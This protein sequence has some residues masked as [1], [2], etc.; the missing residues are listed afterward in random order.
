MMNRILFLAGGCFWGM[1][2]Y[3]SLIP[4]VAETEVGYANG[5][6]QNPTYEQVC[7]HHTGHAETVKV[8]YD[9]DK[10]S[11]KQLLIRFVKAIDPTSVNRQGNDTGMQYRTGIYFTQ[12]EEREEILPVL[13]ELQDQYRAP[14]AVEVLPLDNYY[15]AEDY[16]QKYLIKN[17]SGYCHISG[18]VFEQAGKPLDVENREALRQRLTDIQY[19]VTQENGTEP[20]FQNQYCYEFRKGIYVDIVS[21]EPLFASVDKFESGCG[22]PAFAKPIEQ[23]AVKKRIDKSHGMLRTEVRSSESDS[24]LGHVFEDGPVDKGGL[25]YC[26]NSAALRFIPKDQM[27]QEGYEKYLPFIH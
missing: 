14:F 20:P 24:H 8:I 15:P 3:L 17:P 2:K 1:E 11:I 22:W 7:F 10:L 18:S 13:K 6:T 12:A 26:I 21:G 9:E 16:Y 5:I 23:S 27:K 19:K 25:R 4:G